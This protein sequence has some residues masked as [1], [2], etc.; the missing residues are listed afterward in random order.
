M[1]VVCSACFAALDVAVL[2]HISFTSMHEAVY[3]SC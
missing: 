3:G 1:S 2:T